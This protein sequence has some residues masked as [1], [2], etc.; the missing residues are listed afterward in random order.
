M[1]HRATLAEK[2]AKLI[3][4]LAREVSD[5]RVLDAIRA[6]PRE[7]FVPESSRSVAYDDIALPID[8]GQT[9][10]QPTIVAIMVHALELRRFDR[11]LEIG[12]GSGYQAAVLAELAREVTTVERIPELADAAR[13][14]LTSLGYRNIRIK[15]AGPTLGRSADGPYNAI[16][17]SA[18]APRLPSDLLDQL[19]IGGRL[20]VPVGSLYEQNLMKT[21]RTPDGKSTR[22]L[23]A[24]RFVP[25]IGDGAWSEEEVRRS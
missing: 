2:K 19:E 6:V 17:V 21:I 11:V 25:L 18:A 14:R 15:L 4:A 9:I 16:V 8:A 7:R 13:V 22:S 5:Q 20:V 24:C 3:D 1:F 10:S 12:T 23:G